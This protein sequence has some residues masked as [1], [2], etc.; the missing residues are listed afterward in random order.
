MTMMH[1]IYTSYMLYC[2]VYKYGISLEL[3]I[4][5]AS[6]FVEGG[7]A[8]SMGGISLAY[9]EKLKITSNYISP[10]AESL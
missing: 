7:N 5:S 6:Q 2:V 9:D 8:T 3:P 4:T 10:L 1:E